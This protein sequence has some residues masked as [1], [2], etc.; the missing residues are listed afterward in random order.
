MGRLFLIRHPATEIHPDLPVAQWKL[1]EAGEVQLS[2]LMSAAL[3]RKAR[4]VFSS[5]EHKAAT[6]AEHACALHGT[7]FSLHADL[8]E[9]KRPSR[10]I[11]DYEREVRQLLNCWHE[12]PSGWEPVTS[13]LCR[14]WGFLEAIV[15][16]AQMPVAVVSHGLILSAVRARLLG[17]DVVDLREW[18]GIAFASVATVETEGWVLV[19]DFAV[20]G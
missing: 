18:K 11:D 7:P 5:P 6:V 12:A 8:R 9:L 20:A 15:A 13:G 3:W 10:F 1:S 19:E 2:A 14:A 17:R 16:N 4:H